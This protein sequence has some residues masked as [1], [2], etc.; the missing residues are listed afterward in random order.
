ML[1]NSEFGFKKIKKK[2][3]NF[4]INDI[5]FYIIDGGYVEKYFLFFL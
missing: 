5:N 1:I 3:V 2:I 4:V